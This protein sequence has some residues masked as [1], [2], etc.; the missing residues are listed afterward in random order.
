MEPFFSLPQ[1]YQIFANK[2]AGDISLLTWGGFQ[3]MTAIWVWYAFV[4]K[5]KMILVYQGL[6]FIV[7]GAV[8]V[9]ALL[10]GGQLL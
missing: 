3:I 5:E 7:D 9:G 6:F 10:Y 8:I 1:A 4:H 2:S